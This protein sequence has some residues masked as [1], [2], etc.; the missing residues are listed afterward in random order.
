MPLLS[1]VR[2]GIGVFV[3]PSGG[4]LIGYIVGAYVTGH[5]AYRMK[6]GVEV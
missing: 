3:S 2:G 6:K 4:Y 5:F 1:G